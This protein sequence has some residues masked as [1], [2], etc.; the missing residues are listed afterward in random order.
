MTNWILRQ[1]RSIFL[2]V[3]FV[4]GGIVINHYQLVIYTQLNQWKLIP[5]PERFT[6]LYFDDHTRLPK[7]IVPGET[8]TFVF[9]VN[10]LEGHPTYYPYAVYF[11]GVDGV[12]V[13]IQDGTVFLSDGEQQKITVTTKGDWSSSN[14]KIFVVLKEQNQK[15]HF[16]VSQ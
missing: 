10:N 12:V 14:G 15:I 2:I 9:V 5:Q 1:K 13:P 8:N 6:E 7:I 3:F 4:L 11:Q 16:F